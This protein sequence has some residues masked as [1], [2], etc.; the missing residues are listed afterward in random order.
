MSNIFRTFIAENQS[1]EFS[2]A[3]AKY[4]D[5]RYK[6][7]EVV[8]THRSAYDITCLKQE[9][10]QVLHPFQFQFLRGLWFVEQPSR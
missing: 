7:F 5:R 6:V 3:E 8:L 4:V 9:I 10:V 2:Y 1:L